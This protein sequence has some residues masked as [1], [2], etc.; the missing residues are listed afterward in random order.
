AL[1]GGP[2]GGHAHLIDS[3]IDWGQDLLYLRDWIRAHPEA[4][5]ISIAY[6]GNVSAEIAG[7]PITLP[8]GGGSTRAGETDY[9]VKPEDGDQPHNWGPRPGWYAVSVNYLRGVT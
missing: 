6:F 3:N 7:L 2:A 5:P 9:P 4:S 1:A 8:P